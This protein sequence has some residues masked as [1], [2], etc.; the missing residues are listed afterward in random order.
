MSGAGSEGGPALPAEVLAELHEAFETRIPFNRLLG[1]RVDSVSLDRVVLRFDKTPEKVGNYV[2]DILH[3]GVISAVLDATGGLVAFV[4]ALERVRASDA[5]ERGAI[6]SRVGTI[7]LRV[8]FLRRATGAHYRATGSILRA[9]SRVAVT[10][11]ELHDEHECLVA[12]GTG[13][14]MIA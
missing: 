12:T 5:K 9:G 7:D 11:M 1:I 13:T 6:L 2:R 4:H 10:R 8:D 14:Y 3:G